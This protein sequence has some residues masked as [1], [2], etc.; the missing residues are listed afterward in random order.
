MTTATGRTTTGVSSELDGGL[1]TTTQAARP[2]AARD[3]SASG[4]TAAPTSS[5]SAAVAH[6]STSASAGARGTAPGQPSAALPAA[7]SPDADAR[8]SGLPTMAAHLGTGALA[9]KMRMTPR[10][11]PPPAALAVLPAIAVRDASGIETAGGLP[12]APPRPCLRAQLTR[13][14]K[15]QRRLLRPELVWR[16][17][18]MAAPMAP[19]ARRTFG[20]LFRLRSSRQHQ[21]L[22]P[23]PTS[24]WQW[25]QPLPNPT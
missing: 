21:V 7:T 14:R 4:D 24:S 1:G 6:A 18:W 23:T 2:P 16:S 9:G 20:R 5:L 3:A 10:A 8:Q 19:A 25:H 11:S 17:A 12:S 13:L 15:R 22:S